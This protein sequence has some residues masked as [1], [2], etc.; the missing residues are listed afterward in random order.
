MTT[1]PIDS[2][3]FRTVLGHFLSGVTVVTAIDPD[4]KRPVGMAVGS[5]TSVSLDPPLVAFLPGRTASAWG[6]IHAA[7]SFCVNMLAVNQ[8]QVSR[9]F[10]SKVEDRF[11]GLGWTPASHTGSPRLD[12]ALAWID[13]DI[14]AVHEAGDHLIVIGAVRALDV[15]SETGPLAYYRGGY[16]RF[17]L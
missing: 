7:G 8:E 9:T 15:S 2:A 3:Q 10:A 13:C 14:D 4:T 17:E 1:A 11:S 6:A 12:G 5:F 16:G